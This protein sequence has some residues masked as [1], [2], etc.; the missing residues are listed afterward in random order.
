MTDE[1]MPGCTGKARYENRAQAKIAKKQAERYPGRG[2]KTLHIYRCQFCGMFH[3]SSWN[4]SRE[5]VEA[6]N[7]HT[8]ESRKES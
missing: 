4:N 5:M 2:K 6:V 8:V 3:L 7:K 1:S